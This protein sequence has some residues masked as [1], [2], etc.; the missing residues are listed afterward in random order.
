M[1]LAAVRSERASNHK[2]AYRHG[3]ACIIAVIITGLNALSCCPDNMVETCLTLE[4]WRETAC[5]NFPAPPA[6]EQCPPSDA[7]AETCDTEV[8][9]SRVN[10]DQCCY[11]RPVECI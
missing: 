6:G 11:D 1:S 9:R 8:G 7:V 10:G 3:V 5:K 4:Q 2:R